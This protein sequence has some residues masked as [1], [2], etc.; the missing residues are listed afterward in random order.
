[1][2]LFKFSL[3]L[4]DYELVVKFCPTDPDAK[5]KYTECEKIVRKIRFEKAIAG[6][7]ETE[8]LYQ[9]FDELS[10]QLSKMKHVFAALTEK[11]R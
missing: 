6:N 5:S 9:V 3:S 4:K 2:A 1:M 11:R 10:K 7:E 8:D